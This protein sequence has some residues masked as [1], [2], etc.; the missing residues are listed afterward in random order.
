MNID[1]NGKEQ[2][3]EID[4]LLTKNNKKTKSIQKKKKETETR[5]LRHKCPHCEYR[6]N[7]SGHMRVH[8]RSHSGEK[9]FKCSNEGCAQSFAAKYNMQT[10]AKNHCKYRNVGLYKCKYCGQAFLKSTQRADHIQSAH[11]EQSPH[12]CHYRGCNKGFTT[13]YSLSVHI[14]RHVGDKQWKCTEC[15]GAFI[16]KDALRK[17]TVSV[18]SNERPFECDQCD[19][20]FPHKGALSRHVKS[21]HAQ[22]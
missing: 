20:K 12:R 13:K 15:E 14:K 5:P 7:N 1:A 4:S 17:H 11:P 18:H 2:S 3:F 6:S 10:H 22:N 8:L 16:T 9:P 19:S 21:V